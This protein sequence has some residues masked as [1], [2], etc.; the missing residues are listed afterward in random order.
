MSHIF[1]GWLICLLGS[2]ICLALM[3]YKSNMQNPDYAD[4]RQYISSAYNLSNYNIYSQNLRTGE[5][6]APAIGR[7]PGF[8]LILSYLFDQKFEGT[9][10]ITPECLLSEPGCGLKPYKSAQWLNRILFALAGICLSLIH[11]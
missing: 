3:A 11:I 2:I 7:E 6:V 4:S 5:D 10:L 8:P 1:K 9:E